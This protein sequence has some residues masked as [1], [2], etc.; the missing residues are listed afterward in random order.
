MSYIQLQ[1]DYSQRFNYKQITEKLSKVPL[2]YD[3][4]V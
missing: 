3:L 4:Y 1:Y 2:F